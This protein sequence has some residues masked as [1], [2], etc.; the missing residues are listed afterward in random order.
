MRTAALF[1]LTGGVALAAA[2]HGAPIE[3]DADSMSTQTD[4]GEVVFRGGVSARTDDITL[5]ADELLV[6]DPENGGGEVRAKGKPAAV[7][8]SNAEARAAQIVLNRDSQE[9]RLEGGVEI[10]LRADDGGRGELRA[11]NAAL[12]Y[13]EDARRFSARG[14]PVM[15]RWQNAEGGT[16]RARAAEI[17]YD[18]SADT[19][20]LSGGAEITREDSVVR[21]EEIVYRIKSEDLQVKQKAGERVRAVIGGG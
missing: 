9:A 8:S 20:R 14:A 4:G 6:A 21:G 2:A 12:F 11:D 13:A 3:I 17:E 19:L 18:E 5:T 10:V 16:L 1:L 7:A 15:L